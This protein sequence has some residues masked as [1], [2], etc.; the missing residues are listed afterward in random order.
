[1]NINPYYLPTHFPPTANPRAIKINGRK[2]GGGGQ[3]RRTLLTA[4]MLRSVSVFLSNQSVQQP[5]GGQDTQR[6]NVSR[7][8]TI[9]I[10]NENQYIIVARGAKRTTKMAIVTPEVVATTLGRYG[11]EVLVSDGRDV[12][13]P[14]A[15]VR[16]TVE[17]CRVSEGDQGYSIQP[18][19]TVVNCKALLPSILLQ[20]KNNGA[21]CNPQLSWKGAHVR[22][23]C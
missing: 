20:H 11:K 1:M 13:S 21:N 19:P 17:C 7:R 14:L 9:H 22:C 4:D 2:G 3:M 23:V 6:G 16:A 18:S 5:C 10:A 15:G 8:K 12:S